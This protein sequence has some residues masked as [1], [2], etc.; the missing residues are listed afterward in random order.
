VGCPIAPESAAATLVFGSSC[1]LNE[2]GGVGVRV[3]VG[4]VFAVVLADF[5]CLVMEWAALSRTRKGGGSSLLSLVSL[6]GRVF[7]DAS[8][9]G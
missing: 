2:G 7:S 5:A 8:S 4:S 1:A 9:I 3:A 6:G